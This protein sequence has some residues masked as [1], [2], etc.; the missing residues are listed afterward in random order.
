MLVSLIN[1]GD[2]DRCVFDVRN[3]VIVIG[4]GEIVLADLSD[5]TVSNIRKFYKTDTLLVG[6]EGGGGIHP[7]ASLLSVMDVLKRVDDEPY[8]DLLR[9]FWGVSPPER[10][11]GLRPTREQIRRAC[12]GLVQGHLQRTAPPRDS[13]RP[14]DGEI[15]ADAPVEAQQSD[16]R[17]RT[18]RR[19]SRR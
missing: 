3:R 16:R 6:P 15:R 14:P 18:G 12:R 1:L 8:D 7:P 4:V 19:R 13:V 10:G 17:V 11:I 9:R 2:G 5:S